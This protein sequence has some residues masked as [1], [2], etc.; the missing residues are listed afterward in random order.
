[1]VVAAAAAAVD[2]GVFAP[3]PAAAATVAGLP[4]LSQFTVQVGQSFHCTS[5]GRGM[6][7]VLRSATALPADPLLVG[8]GYRLLFTG[9]R[10]PGVAGSPSSIS[11]RALPATPLFLAPVGRPTAVRQYEAIVDPRRPVHPVAVPSSKA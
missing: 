7:L 6:T 5:A 4:T 2:W 8:N 1:V 11:S 3:G 9:P 10:S